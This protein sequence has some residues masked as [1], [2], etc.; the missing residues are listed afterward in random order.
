MRRFLNFQDIL[1]M[2]SGLSFQIDLMSV[3][4]N[5]KKCLITSVVWKCRKDGLTGRRT[6]TI[7][8]QAGQRQIM[9]SIIQE[10]IESAILPFFFFIFCQCFDCCDI[11][12]MSN[13]TSWKTVKQVAKHVTPNI[14]LQLNDSRKIISNEVDNSI[15]EDWFFRCSYSA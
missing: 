7:Q 2:I 9:L 10:V 12:E 4:T 6:G 5:K 11:E 8:I 13:G 1:D 14:Q 15:M 3:L